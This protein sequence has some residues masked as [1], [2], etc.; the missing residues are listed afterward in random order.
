[1]ASHDD[2][3][4]TVSYAYQWFKNGVALAGATSSTL[5]LGVS[6]NGDKGNSITVQVTPSAAGA[7]GS[8]VTSAAV[9]VQDSAPV[10][11]SV[12]ITPASPT[13]NTILTANVASHDDDGDPV[14]YAY[15][16]F[17]NGAPLAGAT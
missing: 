8:A 13:T 11:D 17:K 4:D 1:V 5:D 2:D 10:V 16:W 9:T 3:G 15:Q 6:G 12:S 7:T 14:T